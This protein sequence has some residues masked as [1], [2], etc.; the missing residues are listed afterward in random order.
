MKFDVLNNGGSISGVLGKTWTAYS[1]DDKG[2]V[3]PVGAAT[4]KSESV[5]DQLTAIYDLVKQI[6][7]IDG[8]TLLK[9]VTITGESLSLA[10][11]TQ[12]PVKQWI[13]SEMKP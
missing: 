9:D 1:W 13:L 7:A 11:D 10:P 6:A 12:S 3:S 2:N 4:A 8:K 5:A